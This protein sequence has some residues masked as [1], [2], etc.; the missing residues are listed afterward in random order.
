[1]SGVGVFGGGDVIARR[2]AQFVQFFCCCL[3]MCNFVCMHVCVLGNREKDYMK[4]DL[5]AVRCVVRL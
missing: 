4:K 5:I 3:Y 2:K 1:M